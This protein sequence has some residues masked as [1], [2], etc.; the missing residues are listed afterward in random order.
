MPFYGPQTLLDIGTELYL[1]CYIS[2]SRA[3]NYSGPVTFVVLEEDGKSCHLSA[4]N[5]T[6]R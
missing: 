3:G 2:E 5:F 4:Y 1:S 6:Y